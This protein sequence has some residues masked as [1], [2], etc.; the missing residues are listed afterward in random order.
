MS[1]LFDKNFPSIQG[2]MCSVRSILGSNRCIVLVFT[3]I[4]C[5]YALSY[6]EKL[7][8]MANKYRHMSVSFLLINSNISTDE[9]DESIQAMKAKFPEL[10]IPYI[11][12]DS[13]ILASYFGATHTPECYLLNQSFELTFSGPIDLRFKNPEE[14]SEGQEGFWPWDDVPPPEPSQT[15]LE[16]KINLYLEGLTDGSPQRVESIG[17]SLK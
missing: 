14:W 12:D 15:L 2:Y 10:E 16:E 6:Y 13:K 5:P 8:K 3:S 4:Q 1:D 11:K 17:C 9:D 7:E